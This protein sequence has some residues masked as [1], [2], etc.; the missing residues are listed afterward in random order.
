[1]MVVV[2]VDPGVNV[3]AAVRVGGVEVAKH[4]YITHMTREAMANIVVPG[5]VAYY[6]DRNRPFMVGIIGDDHRVN[7]LIDLI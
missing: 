1:M 6:S 4:I 5:V 2:V 3:P 7:G